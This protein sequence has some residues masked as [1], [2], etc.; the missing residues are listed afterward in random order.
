M[1]AQIDK[2]VD[3]SGRPVKRARVF[4]ASNVN[5]LADN[6]FQYNQVWGLKFKSKTWDKMGRIIHKIHRQVIGSLLECNTK[7]IVY[8]IN[9]GCSMCPCSPGYNVYNTNKNGKGI[10]VK[11][12]ADDAELKPLTD[13]LKIA[14]LELQVE[15]SEHTNK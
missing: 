7:D 9:C 12:E 2:I 11:I 1:N 6:W 10:F 14:D 5:E 4:V 13:Y 8:S 3:Y 15:I